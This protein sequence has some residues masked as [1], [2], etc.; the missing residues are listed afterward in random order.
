MASLEKDAKKDDITNVNV[1]SNKI[2]RRLSVSSKKPDVDQ[3]NFR[4][5]YY[6]K[7]GF[8][9][10]DERKTLE[11]LLSEDPVN[12]NKLHNFALQFSIPS[13]DRIIVWKFMLAILRS[14]S[15]NREYSWSWKIRPYDDII[16][17]IQYLKSPAEA[18]QETK[19][20]THAHL[21][22]IFRNKMYIG[23]YM[24]QLRTWE[25]LN[26]ASIFETM[27]LI[28]NDVEIDA[29]YLSGGLWT[30]LNERHPQEY[31]QDLVNFYHRTLSNNSLTSKLYSHCE[32]IGLNEVIPL[33]AWFARG[34]AGVLHFSALEKIW[35]KVIGGS[36]KILAYVALTRV[37]LA[38]NV[39]LG[40]HT[41]NEAIRCLT[42]ISED[43]I[44]VAQKA[45]E[46]W[47]KDGR[48][49]LAQNSHNNVGGSDKPMSQLSPETNTKLG[50]KRQM[51]DLQTLH[52]INMSK[53]AVPDNPTNIL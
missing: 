31:I 2:E 11:I 9:G 23:N 13:F 6:E 33:W 44:I 46:L 47:N 32:K 20:E 29:Y 52:Q 35:D 40:C 39:L 16:R 4:S 45:I 26:F 3:R 53:G 17:S 1:N 38:Q 50:Y 51:K 28:A 8:R 19:A 43:D 36:I 34:F 41:A 5:Q 37:E 12:L 15:A 7:V 21:W 48:Q 27:L 10:V 25:P 49:L 22:M 14:S 42:K 30:C 18:T 24:D